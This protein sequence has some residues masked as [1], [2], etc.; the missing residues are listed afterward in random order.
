MFREHSIGSAPA[1]IDICHLPDTRKIC[2]IVEDDEETVAVPA[3]VAASPKEGQDNRPRDQ[4]P[5]RSQA[6]QHK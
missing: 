1:L 5:K 2:L 3:P 6:S 4:R